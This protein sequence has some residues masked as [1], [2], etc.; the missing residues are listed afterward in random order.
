[1]M[2]MNN[3]AFADRLKQIRL[4]KSLTQAQVA[5]A[6]NFSQQAIGKWESGLASPDPAS[7][8]LL[9]NLFQI[10]VDELL[11]HSTVMEPSAPYQTKAQLLLEFIDSSAFK[12]AY[13]LEDLSHEELL[14]YSQKI[15]M[16]LDLIL[17]Q[18]KKD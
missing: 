6:L 10:S 18:R 12:A 2:A 3:T 8:C 7:L 11:N 15:E 4:R 16:I 17:L 13:Q 9:A 14:D 1:M 5:D